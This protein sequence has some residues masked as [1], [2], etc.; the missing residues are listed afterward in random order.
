[1]PPH[2]QDGLCRCT[3]LPGHAILSLL[4]PAGAFH[5]GAFK[6]PPGTDKAKLKV[7]VTLNLNGVVNVEQVQL[8]E[9]EE[10]EEEVRPCGVCV[11]GWGVGGGGPASLTCPGNCWSLWGFQAHADPCAA[12]GGGV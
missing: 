6:V 10:Y 8:L 3:A 2:S 1:M 12:A 5:V 9:E 4:C 11:G 7:K